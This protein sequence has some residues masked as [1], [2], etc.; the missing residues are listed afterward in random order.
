MN[1]RRKACCSVSF[2][3]LPN[4]QLSIFIVQ[5]FADVLVGPYSIVQLQ[6]IQVLFQKY[7]SRHILTVF[8]PR[9][10]FYLRL[11]FPTKKADIL[12][13]FRPMDETLHFQKAA[14]PLRPNIGINTGVFC[15]QA[16]YVISFPHF[17]SAAASSNDIPDTLISNVA[18]NTG[19]RKEHTVCHTLKEDPALQAITAMPHHSRISPKSE[20]Q[21]PKKNDKK[22]E[23]G[24]TKY[25]T[26]QLNI[27]TQCKMITNNWGGAKQTID[28]RI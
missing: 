26:T 8:S 1:S 21:R 28:R 19:E 24:T 7:I 3:Q 14:S 2:L 6:H 27:Y 18:T 12:V 13:L 9:Y 17:L 20:L 10:I 16:R 22:Y 5:Q 15:L 25:Y 23:N 4:V 11:S